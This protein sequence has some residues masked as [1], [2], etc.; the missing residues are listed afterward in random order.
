MLG[1]LI[2][3]YLDENGIKYS[4]VAE[5][6]GIA[7]NVFSAIINGKRKITAEEYFTICFILKL[8]A[9]YFAEKLRRAS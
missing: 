7:A 8:D 6:A 4:F 9:G 5:E 2:K 1:G 3:A